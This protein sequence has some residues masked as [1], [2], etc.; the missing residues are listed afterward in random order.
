MA[1]RG[2][3]RRDCCSAEKMPQVLSLTGLG[4]NW[5]ESAEV[6]R[7][8]IELATHGFSVREETPGNT[9]KTGISSDAGAD[10]GAVETKLAHIGPDLQGIID[11]WP[12][13][14]D[15]IKAGILAMVRAAGVST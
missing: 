5:R 14:P 8:R 7:A 15:A 1:N 3:W 13:L 6:V 2:D 12:A 10:A 11:A 4:G 9:G